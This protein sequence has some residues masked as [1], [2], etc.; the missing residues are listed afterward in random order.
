MPSAL[1]AT[2]EPATAKPGMLSFEPP[3]LLAAVGPFRA[4]ISTG[5]SRPTGLEGVLTGSGGLAQGSRGL[6]PR[7]H[8]E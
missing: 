2:A 8:Q 5:V 1:A 4:T 7:A 6:R 3:P